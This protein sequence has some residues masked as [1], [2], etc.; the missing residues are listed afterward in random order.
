MNFSL[1]RAILGTH[2]TIY[3]STVTLIYELVDT[4]ISSSD[5]HKKN[6]YCTHIVYVCVRLFAGYYWL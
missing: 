4:P 5:L 2:Y 1:R 3:S 6:Y